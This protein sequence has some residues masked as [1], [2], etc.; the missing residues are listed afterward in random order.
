ML[1]AEQ[2]LVT[3]NQRR[4]DAEDSNVTFV[5]K[6]VQISE[7]AMEKTVTVDFAGLENIEKL[8]NITP[9]VEANSGVDVSPN[10]H[11]DYGN[12]GLLQ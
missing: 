12:L 7:G 6:T 8:Q 1:A 9:S 4:D 5:K 11:K 10:G 3:S 2:V